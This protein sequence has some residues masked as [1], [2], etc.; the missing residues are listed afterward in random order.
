MLV[1]QR[2]GGGENRELLFNRYSVSATEAEKVRESGNDIPR[3]LYLMPLNCML[4]NDWNG[5]IPWWSH[6]EDSELPLPGTGLNPWLR[7]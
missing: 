4:E 2:L 1:A 7:N 5:G 3:G 6:G